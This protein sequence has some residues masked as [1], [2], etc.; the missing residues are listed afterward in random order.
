MKF[1]QTL[2]DDGLEIGADAVQN[3]VK[4]TALLVRQATAGHFHGLGDL[5]AHKP[6]SGAAGLGQF[7]QG[8]VGG[9]VGQLPDDQTALFQLAQSTGNGGLVLISQLAQ[10]RGSDALGA[11]DHGDQILG[12]GA[13]QAVF[14]HL[15]PL[16]PLDV[17]IDLGNG[18]GK[19]FKTS[20]HSIHPNISKVEMST[21]IL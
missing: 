2:F 6:G 18:K 9:V 14:V 19:F 5:F 3:A 16:D 11:A 17:V 1:G 8:T 15:V 13:L 4:N 10:L 12:M 20:Q 7:E 21:S